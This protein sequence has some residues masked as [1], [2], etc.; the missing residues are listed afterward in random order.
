MWERATKSCPQNWSS[1]CKEMKEWMFI[2]CLLH[3]RPI[4]PFKILPYKGTFS[5]MES[6]SQ[7]CYLLVHDQTVINNR[8]VLPHIWT[9]LGML[10]CQALPKGPR[11]M[12]MEKSVGGKLTLKRQESFKQWGRN[13]L[14]GWSNEWVWELTLDEWFVFIVTHSGIW[15]II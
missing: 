13:S 7:G 9:T 14:G 12:L 11:M 8:S 3:V 5:D 15:E 1:Q 6:G 2:L 10:T 4:Y